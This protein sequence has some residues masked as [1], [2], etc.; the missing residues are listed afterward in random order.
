MTRVFNSDI[1][2]LSV[3]NKNFE[4]SNNYYINGSQLLEVYV[5]NPYVEKKISGR[6]A[7]LSIVHNM[8]M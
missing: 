8:L 7:C 1:K 2:W 5:F 3:E 4:S 6:H